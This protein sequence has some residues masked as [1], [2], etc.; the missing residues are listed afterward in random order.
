MLAE[1]RDVLRTAWW[2]SVFPGLAITLTVISF[3][4]IGNHVQRRFEGRQP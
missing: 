4:L 3:S 2:P 1:G